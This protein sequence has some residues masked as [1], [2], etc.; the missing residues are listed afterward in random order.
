MKADIAERYAQMARILNGKF[1]FIEDIMQQL[2]TSENYARKL[3]A[4][5]LYSGHIVQ[6]AT[7]GLRGRTKLKFTWQPGKPAPVEYTRK[8]RVSIKVQR[9][10]PLMIALYGA[11]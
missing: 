4:D 7:P 6:E 8:Q 5:L 10:D 11:A 9:T 2:R 3:V 1:L